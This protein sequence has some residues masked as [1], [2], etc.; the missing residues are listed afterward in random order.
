FSAHSPTSTPTDCSDSFPAFSCSSLPTRNVRSGGGGICVGF[1]EE[2][3]NR[4]SAAVVSSERDIRPATRA[5]TIAPPQVPMARS[6]AATPPPFPI[7]PAITPD[8]HAFTYPPAIPENQRMNRS[9]ADGIC[10]RGIDQHEQGQQHAGH[11]H[12]IPDPCL[13]S[14]HKYFARN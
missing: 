4:V 8:S 2:P 1:G 7:K 5:P 6:I 9:F 3:S 12:A 13:R 14:F 11:R 10:G